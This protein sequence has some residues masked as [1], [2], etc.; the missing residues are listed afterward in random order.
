MKYILTLSFVCTNGNINKVFIEDIRPTIP[1]ARII[2]LMNTII[3][4]NIFLTKDG[5]FIERSSA[6]ITSKNKTFF[7]I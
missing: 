6:S 2:L 5:E 1:K 7:K 4:K 3:E